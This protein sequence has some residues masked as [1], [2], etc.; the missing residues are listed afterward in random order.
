[1]PCDAFRALEVHPPPALPLSLQLLL[2]QVAPC[3]SFENTL[4][5]ETRV[6]CALEGYWVPAAGEFGRRR[7][8][9]VAATQSA[10]PAVHQLQDLRDNKA[11]YIRDSIPPAPFKGA[12]TLV[13]T[14]SNKENWGEFDKSKGIRRVLL[15]VFTEPEIME[16]RKIAFDRVAGCSEAEV[17]ARFRK[18]GGNARN[19]LTMATDLVW[20]DELEATP[21]DVTLSVLQRAVQGPASLHAS[22]TNV[23][24]LLNLVPRGAMRDSAVR[25]RDAGEAAHKRRAALLSPHGWILYERAVSKVRAR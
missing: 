3:R 15:P 10:D 1:M 6:R 16:L 12:F 18:W 25:N 9:Y 8:A 2:L 24:H 14:S 22:E 7:Q 19:V 17:K 23:H 13:V 20:Q 4:A 11:L 5:D 21:R